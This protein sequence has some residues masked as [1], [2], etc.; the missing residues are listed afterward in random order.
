MLSFFL[1]TVQQIMNDENWEDIRRTMEEE[2]VISKQKNF[3]RNE[4]I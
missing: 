1:S 3:G 4:I 2:I